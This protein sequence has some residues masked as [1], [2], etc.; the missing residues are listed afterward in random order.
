MSDEARAVP[1][2]GDRERLTPDERVERWIE[3]LTE[4]DHGLVWTTRGELRA[5]FDWYRVA[6]V[7]LTGSGL[8]GISTGGNDAPGQVLRTGVSLTGS[9]LD[10]ERLAT[11]IWNAISAEPHQEHESGDCGVCDVRR[12][13]LRVDAASIA[14]EYGDYLVESGEP[15]WDVPVTTGVDADV[16]E[17]V[18]RRALSGESGERARV[19]AAQANAGLRTLAD[20][21]SDPTFPDRVGE[22]GEPKPFRCPHVPSCCPLDP[23][24]A[25]YHEAEESGEPKETERL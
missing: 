25:P 18:T 12:D 3:S 15:E 10:V 8:R 16:S 1:V 7:S 14:R 11:A 21:P 24:S 6:G 4:R 9:G 5:L 20:E 13:V 17:Y 2:E 23:D 22:S 19:R